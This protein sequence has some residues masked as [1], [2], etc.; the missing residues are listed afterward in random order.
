MHFR[1]KAVANGAVIFHIDRIVKTRVARATYGVPA[2]PW[3]DGSNPEHCR[4]K[5]QWEK[6]VSGQYHIEGG[7]FPILRRVVF[8][9]MCHVA[10]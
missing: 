6:S 9:L 4:R 7:F 3:V 8:S 2:N 5:N 10:L 1:N